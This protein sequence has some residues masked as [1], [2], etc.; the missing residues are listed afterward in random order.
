M[1]TIANFLV[2]PSHVGDSQTHSDQPRYSNTT[3]KLLCNKSSCE[4]MIELPVQHMR[5]LN[6]KIMAFSHSLTFEINVGQP[7]NARNFQACS[8]LHVRTCEAKYAHIES[9]AWKCIF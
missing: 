2:Q 4:E 8:K 7:S 5:A 6:V 3:L 9:R 1:M